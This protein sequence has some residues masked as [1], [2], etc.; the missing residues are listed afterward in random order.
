MFRLSVMFSNSTIGL[1]MQVENCRF[2]FEH[3]K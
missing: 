3:L 1:Q 2:S